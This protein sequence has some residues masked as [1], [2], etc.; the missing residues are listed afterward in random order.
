[1]IAASR[2]EARHNRAL[3]APTHLPEAKP[4]PRH[5]TALCGTVLGL[6]GRLA[7]Q[8]LRFPAKVWKQ[9]TRS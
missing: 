2:T 6:K 8:A 1:L 5:V 9:T 4:N 7:K 3:W